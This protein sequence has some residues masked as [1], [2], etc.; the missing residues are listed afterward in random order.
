MLKWEKVKKGVA[1]VGKGG[2]LFCQ[3]CEYTALRQDFTGEWSCL[4]EDQQDSH[5]EANF[6][7]AALLWEP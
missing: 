4:S 7:G 2:Q 1:E 6:R 5:A 3:G